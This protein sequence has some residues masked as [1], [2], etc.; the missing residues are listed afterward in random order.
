VL[1]VQSGESRTASSRLLA[2][3]R[4]HNLNLASPKATPR[5]GSKCGHLPRIRPDGMDRSLLITASMGH[6]GTFDHQQSK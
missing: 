6:G 3:A 5:I 2:S 4:P 1:T